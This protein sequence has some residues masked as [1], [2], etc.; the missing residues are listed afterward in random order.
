MGY[1]LPLIVSDIGGP[2]AAVDDSCGIRIQARSPEQYATDIA[3]AITRLVNDQEV[4][5]DLGE[6]ARRRVADIALWDNKV[7]DMEAIW[8]SVLEVQRA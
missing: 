4:R 8:D 6:G 5:L 1:G 3:A 7:R 2:G